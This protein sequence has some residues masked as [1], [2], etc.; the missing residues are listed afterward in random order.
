MSPSTSSRSF[1]S[2]LL[3]LNDPCVFRP[4]FWNC[5][6]FWW[7]QF[8]I[9]KM[10]YSS[11]VHYAIGINNYRDLTRIWKVVPAQSSVRH[12]RRQYI[13]WVHCS[14]CTKAFLL[15][16]SYW[17]VRLS[18]WVHQ[19][20]PEN[21]LFLECVF[22]IKGDYCAYLLLQPRF[23]LMPPMLDHAAK[24]LNYRSNKSLRCSITGSNLL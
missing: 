13:L 16:D 19:S 15:L 1:P 23:S 4:L 5:D 3:P 21:L 2:W 6:C 11:N 7:I 24:K 22:F 12:P 9:R 20:S 8:H 14:C 18:N 17:Q 10:F